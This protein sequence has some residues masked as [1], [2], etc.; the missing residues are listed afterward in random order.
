MRQN[1]GKN[2]LYRLLFIDLL[3][4]IAGL[5]LSLL[6]FTFSEIHDGLA[7]LSLSVA[8]IGI[9]TFWGILIAYND[10]QEE[11]EGTIRIATAVTIIT[12]YIIIV[13]IVTFYPLNGPISDVTKT[14][15]TSFT[16]IVGVVVAFFFGSSAYIRVTEIRNPSP[17]SQQPTNSEPP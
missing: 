13:G 17:S 10:N 2:N 6:D 11:V 1:I 3:L 12:I 5:S 16:A 15:L 14:M 9:I 8:A 7:I 4:L